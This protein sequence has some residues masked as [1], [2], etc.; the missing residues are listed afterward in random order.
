MLNQAPASGETIVADFPDA[1]ATPVLPAI[2]LTVSV[3]FA[4]AN[5]CALAAPPFTS[6]ITCPPVAGGSC[7]LSP[8][9]AQ[10]AM[11]VT[12]DLIGVDS[13]CAPPACAVIEA[14]DQPLPLASSEM[15][16]SPMPVLKFTVRP[17]G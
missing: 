1:S 6:H 5:I 2:P 10:T 4:E 7:T 13:G 16:L 3:V 8:D 9:V 17:V 11:S 14:A 12:A 15:S